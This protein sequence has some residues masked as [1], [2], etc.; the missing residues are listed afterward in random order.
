[1]IKRPFRWARSVVTLTAIAF[2]TVGVF[3]AATAVWAAC[4]NSAGQLS[5]VANDASAIPCLGVS[6]G[7]DDYWTNSFKLDHSSTNL[8]LFQRG[9]D[10]DNNI[11]QIKIDSGSFQTLTSTGFIEEIEEGNHTY[12]VRSTLSTQN[13]DGTVSVK[14]TPNGEN[15]RVIAWHTEQQL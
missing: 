1:M 9:A 7:A 11:V 4:T 2:A 13:E 12:T 14:I 8:V 10:T 3:H 15:P 6:E 5:F